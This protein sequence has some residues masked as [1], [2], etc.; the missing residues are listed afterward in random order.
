MIK[1]DNAT[2]NVIAAYV[3][4][5][6]VKEMPGLPVKVYFPYGHINDSIEGASH[7]CSDKC[8][9]D[10]M[11]KIAKKYGFWKSEPV[12]EK[13]KNSEEDS[14]SYTKPK[15][16]PETKARKGRVVRKTKKPND[17]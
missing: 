8:V 1:R 7:F 6:C 9:I 5:N 4:D 13:V 12:E 2:T 14:K 3:C 11:Q 15:P 10:F 17:P 16:E